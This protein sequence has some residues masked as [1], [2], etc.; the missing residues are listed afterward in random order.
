[1][2][3]VIMAGGSGTRFWPASRELMPKQFL[4]ITGERTMLEETYQRV[5]HFTEDDRIYAV[6]GR[7]HVELVRQLVPLSP[8]NILA[9]PVGRNT[10]ACI[11]LSAAHIAQSAPDA[12]I[13]VLPAD[14]FVADVPGF[15]RTIQAAASVAR[16]GLIVTIGINPT[17]PETG[18][19]YIEVDSKL[20]QP[21]P[22]D[23][24]VPTFRMLRFVEKPDRQ[25][26]LQYLG[27]GRHLW[28]SGIFVFTARTILQEIDGCMPK[29]GEGL[30]EIASTINKDDYNSVLAGVYQGFESISIDYGVME[31]TRNPVLVIKGEF[32]WSDV[33]SWEALYELRQSEQDS[34]SNLMLGDAVE[35]DA[36]RNLVY[37]ESNRL[38]A[39]LGV[40]DL[41]V[42]DTPDAVMIARLDRAQDIRTFPQLLK[43]RGRREV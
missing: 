38:V 35:I 39:L 29:L 32:G 8:R 23:P 21:S 7:N 37:N 4:R 31:R 30:R 34:H 13:V 42:V 20:E 25:T 10:A 36:H 22:S 16:T 12:V 14:H 3:A 33:G 40:D 19:G 18:Y 26:A 2:F 41:I 1:M 6:V 28:N 24:G 43:D 17:R 5:R 9:E 11:G 15:V 27:S